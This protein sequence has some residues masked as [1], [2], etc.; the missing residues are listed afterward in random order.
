M[1]RVEGINVTEADID[2]ASV[3]GAR[4]FEPE[5]VRYTMPVPVRGFGRPVVLFEDKTGDVGADESL[6]GD[7]GEG[8]GDVDDGARREAYD[9]DEESTLGTGTA[10]RSRT[11]NRATCLTRQLQRTNGRGRWGVG[12]GLRTSG[13]SRRECP[14]LRECMARKRWK[15]LF[16]VEHRLFAP[17]QRRRHCRRI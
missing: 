2:D 7:V 11:S 3:N 17:R 8:L 6:D 12:N 1:E 4:I 5:V 14:R 10:G 9:V 16:L 15:R 13:C